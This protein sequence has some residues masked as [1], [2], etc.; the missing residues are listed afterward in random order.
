[1][2]HGLFV[3]GTEIA[4]GLDMNNCDDTILLNGEQEAA[5][6][7]MMSG[8]NVFLTGEAG[9]GKSTLLREF[10]RR[11]DRECIVLAPTGIAAL[12]AGGMTIHSQLMLKPGLLNPLALEPLTDGNRCRVLRAAKTVI[13][14]EISMV[15]SDL[16]CAIDARLRELSYGAS[17]SLPFGGRQMILVGDFM[18][19]PPVV[20]NADE[21]KFIDERLGGPFAFQTDLW[22]AAMFRTVSLRTAHRQSG[23]VLFRS[24][25]NNLRRGNFEGAAKVLNNHCLGDRAFSVPPIFLC[26]TN[27]EAKAVNDASRKSVKGESRSFVARI[28]GQFP[29]AEFPAEPELDLAVGARVMV[30]CNQRNEGVLECAN[31]DIGVITGFGEAGDDVV[32]V[33]LD[34]G[35]TVS[36]TSHTW[37][38]SAYAYENDPKTESPVMKQKVVG[39]FEQIPLRL[40]YAITIHKSQGMSLDSVFLRLGRGCF[41]HGQLYTALSR[42]RALAGLGIDRRLAPEDLIV[43]DA[44]VKF[45]AGLESS[46]G[47]VSGED[48][49]YAEAMQYYLRRLATGSG[50]IPPGEMAQ[51]EFDFAPRIFNHPALTELCRLYERGVIN[52]YDSPVLEPLVRNAISGAG[53][54]EDELAMIKRLI[55]KYGSR[56]V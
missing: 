31:G 2:F 40:A 22:A 13:V 17:K 6:K 55:A 26:T 23:D 12:N 14:D 56:N 35:K 33:R 52:K 3:V 25:L 30:I 51:A 21:R 53:V 19:L 41:D 37:E 24:V 18:Q 10:I 20:G 15:R 16:F 50:A 44:V 1:M 27:R 32:E 47:C 4:T 45:H 5:L 43:D 54:K 49:W 8:V 7:L 38:K 39:S 29:E 46:I 36:L 11:C 9:T 42:C 28:S 48:R 34:S